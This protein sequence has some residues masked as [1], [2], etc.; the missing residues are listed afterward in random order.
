M[1]VTR[2]ALALALFLGGCRSTEIVVP[3]L[4]GLRVEV[5]MSGTDVDRDGVVVAVDSGVAVAIPTNGDYEFSGVAEGSH[6]VRLTG[7]SANCV[8]AEPLTRTVSVRGEVA[9]LVT[10]MLICTRVPLAASGLVAFVRQGHLWLMNPEGTGATEIPN[11]AGEDFRLSPSWTP[12]GQHIVFVSYSGG[13][14]RIATVDR[15]GGN[16]AYLGGNCP[17]CFDPAV[18]PDGRRIAYALGLGGN[19]EDIWVMDIDGTNAWQLTSGPEWDGYPAW[20]PDGTKIAFARD[21][22]I[23]VMNADGTGVTRASPLSGVSDRN[24]VWSPD[25]TTLAFECVA[26]G[27]GHVCTMPFGG[28][29]RTVLTL[30]WGGGGSPTW[31]P[32]GT[33]VMFGGAALGSVRL[34]GTGI[35]WLT[36]GTPLDTEPAWSR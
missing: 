15:A 10:F 36:S 18:S 5:A 4:G 30:D 3:P 35:Q 24:P 26:S 17:Y 27:G 13:M 20:S 12:D 14:A 23:Y 6:V 1:R 8:S 34:D 22:A 9:T 29:P 31:S 21:E 19:D 33:R 25:A 7:Q 32:D 11:Q 16:F 28:G 2:P